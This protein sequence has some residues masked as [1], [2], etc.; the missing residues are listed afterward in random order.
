MNTTTPKV[1]T[2]AADWESQYDKVCSIKTLGPRGYFSHPDFAAYM[3]TVVGDNGY[4]Y[5]GHPEDFDYSLFD[6][7]IVLSHNASFDESLYLY[8]VEKGWYKPCAPLAWHCTAD[9][10]AFLGLPRSLKDSVASAL[11]VTLSKTT[12]DNMAGKKWETMT[13]EFKDEVRKYALDDAV[14]CLQLWEKLSDQW[15]EFERK[16]SATN[17]KIMQRGIPID[18]GLLRQNLERIKQGLFEAETTIPWVRDGEF[19]PLSRKAFNAECRKNA[20]EPPV[21]LAQDSPEA[22]AWF[23][24]HE[25][26]FEWARGVQNWRRTN[27]FLSKLNSFERGL[28]PDGRYY[29]GLMYC[30]ANP[31]CRFS[32]SGGNLNLQNLPRNEMFGVNFRHMIRP[33]E[34]HKLVVVDLSQIEVRTLF[35]WAKDLE[36]LELI[37]SHD[38]IYHVIAVMLGMHDPADGPLRNNKALRQKVKAMALGCQFGLG[39]DGFSAYSG[40]PLDE[41]AAAVDTYQAKMKSVVAFWGQLKRDIEMCQTLGQELVI[42]LPSGRAMRYGTIRRMKTTN[43][44]GKTRFAYLG[45][46][47]RNGMKRDFRLWHGLLAENCIFEQSQ[48]LTETRGWATIKDVTISDKVWD[49]VEF[50]AHDGFKSNGVRPVVNVH[51]VLATADHKFLCQDEWLPAEKAC[52]LPLGMVSFPCHEIQRLHGNEIRDLHGNTTGRVNSQQD[53]IGDGPRDQ[54]PMGASVPVRGDSCPALGRDQEDFHLWE[55]LPP[56]QAEPLSQEDDPRENR[57]QTVLGVEVDD[58]SLQAPN[59]SGV[60][61]LWGPRYQSVPEMA[62]RVPELLGRHEPNVESG[63]DAGPDRQQRGL[64]SGEL[65]LGD[66]AYPTPKQADHQDTLGHVG[67]GSGEWPEDGGNLSPSEERVAP[68]PSR[69]HTRPLLK[70]VG[71]LINCGP[72]NRFVVRAAVGSPILMAHNCAQGLARDIF[73]DMI[74]RVEAAGFPLIFHVHD[75]LVCLV[76]KD[77]AENALS[78]IVQIMSTPP[79]WIPDIPVAAEGHICDCYNK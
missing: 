76:P 24:K 78:E 47:V 70:P 54:R 35:W 27:S 41:A 14:Y 25:R 75:E 6:G 74:L 5:V 63:A 30:G 59:A 36:A 4:T 64:L 77:E 67:T 32:G 23:A 62:G 60:E 17:R 39:A 31:T 1:I 9:M 68:I 2:Y 12:R 21:S 44:A 66:V 45:K 18:E 58:R 28:M 7:N 37:K 15:P 57:P 51:G 61:E 40:M 13:P 38:D 71:D 43:S 56:I 34:G 16:V 69:Y 50:V 46:M 11:G 29:G 22:D 73:S 53:G 3:V 10:V 65:P 49:G 26:E 19:T 55:S 33:K 20:V 48:V 79:S 52:A 42:H 8:G 72:R